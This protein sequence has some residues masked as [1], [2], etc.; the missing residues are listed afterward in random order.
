MVADSIWFIVVIVGFFLLRGVA[1]TVVFFYLLP[2]DD[3][4]PHCDAETLYVQSPGFNR[5]M[6]WFRTSWCPECR[7]EG[8]LRKRPAPRRR[9]PTLEPPAT[10]PPQRTP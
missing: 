6:P 4:C 1:A 10:R 3:R 5:I 8:M 9:A 7:W 2:Q